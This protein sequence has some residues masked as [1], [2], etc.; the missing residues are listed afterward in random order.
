M[1]S[2]E[3]RS[4]L[5]DLIDRIRDTNVLEALRTLALRQAEQDDMAAEMERMADLSDEAISKGEVYTREEV[6]AWLKEQRPKG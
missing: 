5:K 2:I 3:L 6:E 4:E 1:T